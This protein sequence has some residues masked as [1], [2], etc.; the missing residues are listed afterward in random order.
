[1]LLMCRSTASA[2]RFDNQTVRLMNLSVGGHRRGGASEGQRHGR[3]A[4]A[5][6]SSAMVELCCPLT[7]G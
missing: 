2:H 4:S 6:V 5:L 3:R 7:S 1:M